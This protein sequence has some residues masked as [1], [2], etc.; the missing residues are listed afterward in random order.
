MAA[1]TSVLCVSET[2][3]GTLIKHFTIY[4]GCPEVSE[5]LAGMVIRHFESTHES[6]KDMNQQLGS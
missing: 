3:T 6:T 1:I 5:T 2:L 4:L